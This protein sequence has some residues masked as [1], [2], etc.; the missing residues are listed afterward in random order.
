M[1]L[2]TTKESLD[3][4]LESIGGLVHG[5]HDWKSPITSSNY[6]Q[7]ESG[8]YPIIQKLIED[9]IE[10]GWDKKILQ[11]KEKFG[12]LRFYPDNLPHLGFELIGK[13]EADSYKICET[14][15]KPGEFRSDLTWKKTLCAD[16]YQQKHR[17]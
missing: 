15:G 13:A 2:T 14:C 17:V 3:A 4:Y 12:G 1:E 11:V 10:I 7:C 5:Y 9:L 6:F 8:W 16:H